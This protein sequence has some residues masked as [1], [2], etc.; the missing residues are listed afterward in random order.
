MRVRRPWWR[1]K[2]SCAAV[3]TIW[4]LVAYPLSSG[5]VV[6]LV[7]RGW[8]SPDTFNA[9]YLPVTTVADRVGLRSQ[10]DRWEREWFYSGVEDSPL[11]R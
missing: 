3:L 11:G 5:P 8:V 2:R 4:L 7:G 6:Y 10:W 9:I 1:T